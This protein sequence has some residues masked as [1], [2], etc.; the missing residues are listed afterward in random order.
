MKKTLRKRKNPSLAGDGSYLLRTARTLE[1]SRPDVAAMT[2]AAEEAA[3]RLA[4]GGRLWA[5]GPRPL[6]CEI[7]SRAGGF[8]MLRQLAKTPAKPG[9][10]VLHFPEPKASLP[11]QADK[12]FVITLGGSS[13]P[14][15]GFAHR[16]E[17]GDVS[18]TLATVILSWLFTGE[19]IAALTRLGKM[20]VLYQSIGMYDGFPRIHRYKSGEIAFHGD[21]RVPPAAAG[22]LGRRYIDAVTGMLRRVEKEE[23][24][25]LDRAGAW[26]REARAAGKRLFMY[27]MG[28]LFPD[29]IGETAIGRVFRSAVWHA[30]FIHF[31]KPDHVYRSGDLAVHI[32]YQHPPD[33]LLQRARPAGARVVYVSLRADRDSARDPGVI[34]ID[35]MWDWPDAC[36]PIEGYDVPALPASAV[37]NAAIA[38]EIY[39]LQ[40]LRG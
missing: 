10:V 37:V 3:Q 32:G 13:G 27:S 14:G 15:H 7:M 18:P 5:T 28:H 24:R 19:L 11:R 17:A 34:R 4:S 6:V 25:N 23:R 20:P 36:V 16:A 8:M 31:A 12:A 22:V 21:K 26:A 2:A 40:A 38:W 33:E 30:G 35:P 9:D 1:A 39:R 29:E